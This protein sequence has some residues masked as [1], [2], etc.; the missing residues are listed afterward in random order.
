MAYRTEDGRRYGEAQPQFK[1]VVEE[2]GTVPRRCELTGARAELEASGAVIVAS[3]SPD[4]DALVHVAAAVLGTRLRHVFP[5]RPQQAEHGGQLPLHSDGAYVNADIHGQLVKLRDPDEDF[6]VQRCD[7]PA[8]EGGETFLLDG[9][10]LI[11]QLRASDSD[12]ELYDFVTGVDIDYFGLWTN[13]SSRGVPTTP[14]LRR[15]VE[16]TRAGRRVVRASDYAAPAPR[17][18]QAAHHAEL[19]DRYADLLATATETIP[20]FRLE[21]GEV[22]VVDNYRFLHGRDPFTG[23]REIHV[24]TVLSADAWSIW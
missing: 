7:Q 22:L 3:P 13:P 17:D 10:R 21:A 24:L 14:L 23:H 18:P 19:L 5:V 4:A 8:L 16:Y 12:P 1:T 20:R 2:L 6:L 15:L 9:Y 11:D